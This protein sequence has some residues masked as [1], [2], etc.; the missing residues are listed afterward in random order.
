MTTTN[1]NVKCANDFFDG[2]TIRITVNGKP[3]E[4]SV[5]L[6][7]NGMLDELKTADALHVTVQLNGVIQR[8]EDFDAVT[9][10]ENDS[11]EP[12]YFMGGGF[13]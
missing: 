3:A 8:R 10:N 7:I 2:G 4:V 12:L 1:R 5:G 9:L 6:S 13:C 11:V